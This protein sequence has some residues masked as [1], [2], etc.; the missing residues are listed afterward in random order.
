MTHDVKEW[1]SYDEQI[2]IL[3]SRGMGV[4]DAEEAKHF[5]QRV[6]YYRLSGY[7]YPFRKF[8]GEAEIRADDFLEGSCFSDIIALYTFDRRLK[9]LALDAIERI[10][11]AIQAEIAHLLGERDPFAHENSNELHG[12]FS[13]VGRN[14]G[15]SGH[16]KWLIDYKKL[17]DRT[18]RKSFVKHNINKYRRLPIWVA[19]EVFDFGAMSKLY[20]GMKYQD[21]LYI[22][23]QFGLCEGKHFETW[24]RSFNFIRN[25]AAHHGRLWNCNVL[26]RANIP[27]VKRNLHQLNNARTF[28]YFC[29]IQSVLNVVSPNA[30]WGRKFIELLGTFPN[31]KNGAIKIEDMGVVEGWTDWQIWR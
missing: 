11:L 15:L 27:Y 14:G 4:D 21:K 3:R 19:I 13:R 8:D 24:L 12:N 6:G 28:L 23:S 7:W 5:L 20:A 18:R 17:V 26:E 16:Q 31:V 2:E 10:E 25:T 30:D 29:M 1:K 22:E 9:L